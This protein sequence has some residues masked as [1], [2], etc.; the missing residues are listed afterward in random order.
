MTAREQHYAASTRRALKNLALIGEEVRHARVA[1]GMAQRVLARTVR[2][3]QSKISR[4]EAG[5]ILQLSLIDATRIAGAVGLDLSVKTYV[6]ERRP[7]DAAQLRR[8]RELLAHVAH[9]L[10]FRIEAVLPSTPER[11]FEQ[12]A[13]D[14]LLSGGGQQTGVELEVQLYDL[15]A[16]IRR[17]L[18]KSRDAEV[19]HLLVAVADTRTNR[20]V[21]RD[22]SALL[23]ELP[24]LAKRDVV[25][26]LEAGRHPGSGIVL[27]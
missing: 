12:R 3:S 19:D 1:L 23:A 9:P 14:A 20:R 10:T 13:W 18:I 8:L 6:S 27:F 16:Q 5:K 22:N 25:E 2:M 26:A 4:V 17:I 24:M 11:P 15:Q 7:R 21:L